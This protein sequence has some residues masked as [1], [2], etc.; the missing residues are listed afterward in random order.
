MKLN[1]ENVTLK[2]EA[3][4]GKDKR[5]FLAL[6]GGLGTYWT[7]RRRGRG[8]GERRRGLWRRRRECGCRSPHWSSGTHPASSAYWTPC[9]FLSSHAAAPL[10]GPQP[11]SSYRPNNRSNPAPTAELDDGQPA[12]ASEQNEWDGDPPTHAVR[13]K[14]FP[15]NER[16]SEILRQ[17]DTR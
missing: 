15:W 9:P 13:E 7:R 8:W 6:Y 1:S 4:K 2:R 16:I 5:K 17:R 11:P 10:P 12:G 3:E 14:T